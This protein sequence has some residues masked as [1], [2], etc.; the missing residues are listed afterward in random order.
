MAERPVLRRRM[1][2]KPVVEE[3]IEEEMDFDVEEEEEEEEQPVVRRKVVAPA[4]SNVKRVTSSAP[5]PVNKVA[6]VPSKKVVD[7][8]DEEDVEEVAAPVKKTVLKP[9]TDTVMSSM[10]M[11]LISSMAD[12]SSIIIT[13]IADN[14]WSITSGE[15]VQQKKSG[16]KGNDYWKEV[17]D[18]A[19]VEWSKE[20]TA[21]SAEDRIKL[22]KS[23]KVQWKEDPDPRVNQMR[24]TEAYREAMGIEKYKPEYRSRKARK[25]LQMGV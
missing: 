4:T 8:E 24:C 3:P 20:W 18:P 11:A 21:M 23:K 14:K 2:P 10:F 13:K 16:L 12:G 1:A 15:S 22:A 19:Y 25:E 9:V 17:L 7:E 6:P 5:A